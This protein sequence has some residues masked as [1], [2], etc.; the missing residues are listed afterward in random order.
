MKVWR[1]PLQVGYTDAGRQQPVQLKA[2]CVA[3]IDLFEEV[4]VD[5][6]HEGSTIAAHQ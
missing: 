1:Y 3:V 5:C 2:R 4:K 6:L